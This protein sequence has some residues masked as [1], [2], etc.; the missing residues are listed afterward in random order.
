MKFKNKQTNP[1]DC[2]PV[3]NMVDTHFSS[4][5]IEM[6]CSAKMVL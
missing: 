2:T 6:G 5:N 3:F 4:L 1:G